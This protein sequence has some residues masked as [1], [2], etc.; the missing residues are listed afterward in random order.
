MTISSKTLPIGKVSGRYLDFAY[1]CDHGWC[2]YLVATKAPDDHHLFNFDLELVL[3]SKKVTKVHLLVLD[4]YGDEHMPDEI[5]EEILS[6][7]MFK[8][9]LGILRESG[10]I[11]RVSFMEEKV[12][13]V[14][15]P[16]GAPGGVT[17]L[18][19]LAFNRFEPG[20]VVPPAYRERLDELKSQKRPYYLTFPEKLLFNFATRWA[21]YN[22]LLRNVVVDLDFH[23]R[24]LQVWADSYREVGG[25][26][27]H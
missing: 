7:T 25:W 20:L 14:G 21:S 16:E 17:K 11:V 27:Y 10:E 6:T 2:K 5:R 26:Q 13:H 9:T 8:E 24:R 18:T 3:T 22:D 4:N 1:D 15:C 19:C 23:G 12:L